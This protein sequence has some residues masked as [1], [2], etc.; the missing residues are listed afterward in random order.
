MKYRVMVR[1]TVYFDVDADSE[2]EA[3]D[4]GR[5]VLAMMSDEFDGQNVQMGKDTNARLYVGMWPDVKIADVDN[6]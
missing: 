5:D 6:R 2:A 4:K 3:K 1:T